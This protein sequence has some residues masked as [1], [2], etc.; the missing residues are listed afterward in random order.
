MTAAM[1]ALEDDGFVNR[2]VQNNSAGM[3]Q[4]TAGFQQ[5]GLDFIPSVG[6]FI[7][8]DVGRPADEID[9]ALLR[10]GCITRPIAA[11][12]LPN[13]LRITIGRPDENARLLSALSKVID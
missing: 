9:Q 7:A 2:S 4:L 6:N 5:L 8:V 12:G 10:V 11:Y 3:A 1:A 13:H